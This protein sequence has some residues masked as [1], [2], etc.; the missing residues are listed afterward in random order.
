MTGVNFKRILIVGGLEIR[1]IEFFHGN[2]EKT[3]DYKLNLSW[4]IRNN[5][6]ARKN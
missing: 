6:A 3:R 2:D 1:E 4:E 5:I